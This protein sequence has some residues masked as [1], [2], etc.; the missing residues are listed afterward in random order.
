MNSIE[1]F[2]PAGLRIDGRRP[3]E[4]RIPE[5]EMGFTALPEIDG[6]VRYRQGGTVIEACVTGPSERQRR[7]EVF[8]MHTDLII[9]IELAS[10][11]QTT[12]LDRNIARGVA[13]SH[14]SNLK[15]TLKSV[16]ILSQPHSQIT[17]D[18]LVIQEDGALVAAMLN[19]CILALIDAGVPMK[20][21]LVATSVL[22][23]SQNPLME[24][25]VFVDPIVSEE[26]N[27][28]FLTLAYLPNLK[29]VSATFLQGRLPVQEI[30]KP[31]HGLIDTAV[32]ACQQLYEIF[33]TELE[34]R[35]AQTQQFTL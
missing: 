6:S 7:T 23:F 9:N 17:I 3:K 16:L 11:S 21:L 18:I 34:K 25:G 1:K 29:V 19:A 32:H 2:T 35:A 31:T 30:T 22:R 27:A 4:F 28:C 8:D 13:Q 12:L 5:F 26:N 33:K 10:F 14:I 24:N 20:D 15:S